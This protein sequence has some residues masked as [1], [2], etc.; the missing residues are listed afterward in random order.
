MILR[1]KHKDEDTTRA[2]VRRRVDG[3]SSREILD[4]CDNAG[5]GVALAI[6]DYRKEGAKDSLLD[7]QNG[8]I[9]LLGCVEVLLTR[10]IL[11]AK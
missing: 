11:R 5:T 1:H 2:M 3:L 4:W 10:D 9:A 6:N 7:A 8:L